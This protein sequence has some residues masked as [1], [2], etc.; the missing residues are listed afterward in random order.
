MGEI[1]PQQLPSLVVQKRT[2]RRVRVDRSKLSRITP[3]YLS[4]YYQGGC[5][6][7]TKEGRLK[8][9]FRGRKVPTL[10]LG[11]GHSCLLLD[12]QF[13]SFRDHPTQPNLWVSRDLEIQEERLADWISN[14]PGVFQRLA[15]DIV[16]SRLTLFPYM[17]FNSWKKWSAKASQSSLKSVSPIAGYVESNV[18]ASYKNHE[19]WHFS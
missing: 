17:A 4:R 14:T 11:L 1:S 10:P 19:D 18:P 5:F 9:G 8:F 13:T 2:G 6:P 12:F 15:Q 16:R 7:I 3:N